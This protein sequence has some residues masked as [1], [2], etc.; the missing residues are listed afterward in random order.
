MFDGA[1]TQVR[2][3]KKMILDHPATIKGKGKG[4]VRPKTVL[5]TPIE[6]CKS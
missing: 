1:C 3:A 6:Y 5:S 4:I 2:E